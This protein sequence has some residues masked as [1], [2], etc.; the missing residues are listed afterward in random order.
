M[1][2]AIKLTLDWVSS[3]R[4]ET[5]N[6]TDWQTT[7]AMC[8]QITNYYHLLIH[9]W[10]RCSRPRWPQ[11]QFRNR[12][13]ARVDHEWDARS[14]AQRELVM[15]RRRPFSFILKINQP[16]TYWKSFWTQKTTI[17]WNKMFS[18]GYTT[19]TTIKNKT[20]YNTAR[21]STLARRWAAPVCHFWNW[22]P[23]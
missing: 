10:P 15:T 4:H 11:M 14:N 3:I 2:L 5:Q 18:L 17:F 6:V 13:A 1:A 8:T 7:W 16:S 20:R 21:Y 9:N 19:T 22:K 23:N 12:A